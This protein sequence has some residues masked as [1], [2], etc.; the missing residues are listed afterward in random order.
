MIIDQLLASDWE[1]GKPVPEAISEDDCI[2]CRFFV[3]LL[4]SGAEPISPP[5]LLLMG[6]WRL[7]KLYGQDQD[8][9][10]GIATAGGALIII[11]LSAL[12]EPTLAIHQFYDGGFKNVNASSE[13][14]WRTGG[15][16]MYL[17]GPSIQLRWP[18]E[19]LRTSAKVAEDS[20]P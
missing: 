10:T 16:W 12:P 3:C 20:W 15:C 9:S 19:H 1:E 17:S 7:Q 8:K 5:G 18:F 14:K 4:H 2:V 11:D 6:I 13:R